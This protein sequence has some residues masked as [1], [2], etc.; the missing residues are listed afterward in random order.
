MSHTPTGAILQRDGSYAI[1]TNNPAGLITP[2]ELECIAA[3]GRKFQVPYLKIT[4]GQRIIL[5]GIKR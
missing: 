2:E 3:V 5:A 1:M 4:S